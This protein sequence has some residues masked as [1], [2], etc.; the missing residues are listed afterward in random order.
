MKITPKSYSKDDTCFVCAEI[1]DTNEHVIPKWLQH[2]FDL[3][4]EMLVIPNGTSIPY[5]ALTIPMCKRCNSEVFSPLEKR[6]ENGLC[7]DSDIWKWA[8]KIHYGLCYKEKFLA[9]D[10]KNP[11]R[12]I[13]EVI[14]SNDPLEIE[15]SFLYSV[16]GN[17]TTTPDPFG[18]VFQFK[19]SSQQRF[20][21]THFF[22]STSLCINIGNIGYVVFLKDGQTLKKNSGTAQMHANLV[23]QGRVEAM[24]FFYAN[25]VENFAR[26][27][28]GFNIILSKGHI[29]KLGSTKVHSE[30]PFNKERFRMICSHLGLN[31]IEE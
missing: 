23:A 29:V 18:S 15:R 19:F 4:D 25:C 13:A 8:N 5:R 27:K 31:W 22:E 30:E 14:T 3:W 9:W 6:I 2:R 26:Q 1:A 7:S 28:L 16:S 12:K 10:R 21:F 11:E 17:F 20:I 24:L